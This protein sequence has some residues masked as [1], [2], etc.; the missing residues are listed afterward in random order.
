MLKSITDHIDTDIIAIYI[1]VLYNNR[2]PILSLKANPHAPSKTS[3]KKALLTS[4][5]L[6]ASIRELHTTHSQATKALRAAPDGSYI[7][8][9][10][11]KDTFSQHTNFG[12]FVNDPVAYAM[13]A[14][15]TDPIKTC[16]STFTTSRGQTR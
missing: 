13:L 4:I 10:P 5:S 8:Y 3:Y 2:Y 16:L 12:I 1:S 7:I 15:Q 6:M 9:H 14:T 11:K